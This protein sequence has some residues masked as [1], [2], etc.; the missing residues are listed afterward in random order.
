MSATNRGAERHIDDAYFTPAWATKRLVHWWEGNGPKRNGIWLEPCVGSG[1]IVRAVM[2]STD[3]NISKFRPT[4]WRV[5]DINNMPRD[6]PLVNNYVISDFTIWSDWR[7]AEAA[8]GSY[9]VV[10]SN[11]PFNL[12]EEIIRK[13]MEFTDTVVMFQRLNFLGSAKR[14]RWLQARTPTVLVLPNRPSM[15]LNKKGKPG[16]D[17]TEYGWFVWDTQLGSGLHILEPTHKDELAAAKQLVAK[18]HIHEEI[19]SNRV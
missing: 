7:G 6:M 3:P 5:N 11:P 10:I 15:G 2:E 17:A 18:G 13:A 4:D 16:T 12:A 1:A 14:C 19:D 8:K 9:T